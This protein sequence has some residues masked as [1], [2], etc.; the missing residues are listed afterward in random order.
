[1]NELEAL[2]E[3][4]KI[5]RVKLKNA[6]FKKKLNSNRTRSTSDK[7]DNHKVLSQYNHFS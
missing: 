6:I 1:M 7:I 3:D 2:K 4:N 5:L